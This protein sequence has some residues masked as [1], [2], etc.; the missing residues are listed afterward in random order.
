MSRIEWRG[1]IFD[2]FVSY[3]EEER[4]EYGDWGWSQLCPKH[5]KGIKA[6]HGDGMLDDG[7]SGICGVE[8]CNRDSDYYIDFPLNEVVPK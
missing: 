4:K 8:G 1:I 5:A 3:D 2:D 7:G 6:L